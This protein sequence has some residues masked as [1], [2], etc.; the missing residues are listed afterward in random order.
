[1]RVVAYGGGLNSTAMLVEAV[2]REIPIDLILFADTGGEKPETYDYVVRLSNW[3]Q[4]KGCPRIRVCCSITKDGEKLTLEENCLRKGM[5]PSLSY[6]FK[7]C[8]HRWKKEPQEKFTNNWKPAKEFWATGAKIEKWIGFD[9]DEEHRA[10]IPGCAKYTYRY[11]L[12]EWD[13]GREECAAAITAAGLPLPIKSACFFCPASKKRDILQLDC[14]HPALAARA[15]SLEARAMAAT[16]KSRNGLGGRLNW[17]NFLGDYKKQGQLF[18][19]AEAPETEIDML[20]GCF[21]GGD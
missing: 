5:L 14:E 12:C 8:S 13:M 10:K 2:R 4:S 18:A 16:V 1:M 6:G 3:L 9:A 11:V 17:T 20:C 19:L 15:L 7:K 21:D